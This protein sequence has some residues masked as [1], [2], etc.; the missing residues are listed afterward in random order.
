MGDENDYT[1]TRCAPG[2]LTD[3]ERARCIEI[4]KDGEA[5]DIDTT[6][7]EL[8]HSVALVLARRGDGIVGVGTIKRARGWYAAKISRHSGFTVLADTPELGY[9]AVTKG[10][11]DKHLSSRIFDAL[12]TSHDGPLFA[13]TDDAKMKHLL[14][15]GGFAKK[16]N[17]WPGQRGMLSQWQKAPTRPKSTESHRG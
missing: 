13:T 17:E 10:H 2:N 4:L 7:E 15:K 6:K 12:L 14:E 8:P 5:V 11:R 9:V 1:V 16:G 3:V